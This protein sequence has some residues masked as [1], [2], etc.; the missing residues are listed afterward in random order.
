MIA[1]IQNLSPKRTRRRLGR[2]VNRFIAT[3]VK[4]TKSV[5]A[6][7]SPFGCEKGQTGLANEGLLTERFHHRGG[8]S[9]KS[10][11]KQNNPQKTKK[12]M[13]RLPPQVV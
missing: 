6:R 13:T 4:A 5:E 9:K 2:R 12:R 3:A 7:R 1:I 10:G 11:E 8:E